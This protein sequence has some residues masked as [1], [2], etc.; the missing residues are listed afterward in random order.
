MTDIIDDAFTLAEELA[1]YGEHGDEA[2]EPSCVICDA[3][4]RVRAAHKAA[5]P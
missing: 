3:I 4:R 1:G 5:H 2:D